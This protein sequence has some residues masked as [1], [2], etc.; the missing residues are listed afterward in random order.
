RTPVSFPDPPLLRADRSVSGA[1]SLG[2]AGA[3]GGLCP[4]LVGPG[5][6]ELALLLQRGQLGAQLLL[7]GF[8]LLRELVRFPAAPDVRG[9]LAFQGGDFPCE[10]SRSGGSGLRRGAFRSDRTADGLVVRGPILESFSQ[11]AECS[12]A[13]ENLIARRFLLDGESGGTLLQLSPLADQLLDP[14][15]RVRPP[16][17]GHQQLTLAGIQPGTELL[18]T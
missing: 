5:S 2:L 3:G 16:L 13:S 9:T 6:E 10:L 17:V 4:C 14:H 8:H 15:L 1:R 7:A 18:E 11:V 12:A